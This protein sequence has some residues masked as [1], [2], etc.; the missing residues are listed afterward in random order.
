MRAPAAR[1]PKPSRSGLI[2]KPPPTA[3]TGGTGVGGGGALWTTG[4]AASTTGS[5]QPGAG[6]IAAAVAAAPHSAAAGAAPLSALNA[7][8]G[9]ICWTTGAGA[10]GALAIAA[11]ELKKR[12]PTTAHATKRFILDPPIQSLPAQWS[13]LPDPTFPVCRATN[14]PIESCLSP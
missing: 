3:S 12:E 1:A 5:T 11:D 4:G 2:P 8:Q 7:A 13:W 14:Y 6:C 10:T 9:S